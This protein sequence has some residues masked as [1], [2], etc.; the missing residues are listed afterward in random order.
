MHNV[1]KNI[2]RFIFIL[3]LIF[4]SLPI[5]SRS[6]AFRG[7][8]VT[9]GLSD[10]VVN[11]IYKDSLGYVWLGTGNSLECF[12]GIH[13]KH[14]LIPGSDEKLKRVNAKILIQILRGFGMNVLAYDLYPDYNFAREHQVVYCTLDELYH[15]SDI[16]SL[17]CPLTEQTK[18]LINDY[19]ISKMKDGVMIINTGRGPESTSPFSTRF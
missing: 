7:L 6:Y 11:A 14:Y 15:S 1:M 10:L 12:D 16:I 13:F 4:L 19:S 18:Y 9:E 8:S 5:F 2:L 17:H 3:F